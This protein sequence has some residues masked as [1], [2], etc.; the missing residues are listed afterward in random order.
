MPNVS[1]GHGRSCRGSSAEQGW[2]RPRRALPSQGR[3][4]R[5]ANAAGGRGRWPLFARSKP[6]GPGAHAH[7]GGLRHPLV[8]TATTRHRP[9]TWDFCKRWRV[10]RLAQPRHRLAGWLHD[11]QREL[12]SGARRRTGGRP[13]TGSPSACPGWPTVWT[14][15]TTGTRSRCWRSSRHDFGA[16]TGPAC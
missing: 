6:G 9:C 11:H 13:P 8:S 2:A 3:V 1:S 14:H 15:C 10:D 12:P 4:A 16:G 5:G 7:A